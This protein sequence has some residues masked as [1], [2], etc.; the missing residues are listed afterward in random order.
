MHNHLILYF[1]TRTLKVFQHLCS[2]GLQVHPDAKIAF[3]KIEVIKEDFG[4]AFALLKDRIE[5]VYT[6]IL[7]QEQ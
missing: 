4:D 7:L 2:H 1:V 5:S 6:Q 3:M